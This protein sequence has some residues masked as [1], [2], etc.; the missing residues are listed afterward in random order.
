[1]GQVAV[2]HVDWAAG[3]AEFG[4]LMIGEP[5]A[6][7]Q[8]LARAATTLLVDTVLSSWGLREIYLDVYTDNQ[9][10]VAIYAACGF[11]VTSTLANVTHMARTRLSS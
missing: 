10:A 9:P 4:R 8:G 5:A 6:R 1:V 7:G 3:R 2:Y 11:R